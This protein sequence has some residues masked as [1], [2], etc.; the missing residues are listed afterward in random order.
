MP[1]LVAAMQAGCTPQQLHSLVDEVAGSMNPP[2]PAMYTHGPS[3][4]LEGTAPPEPLALPPGSQDQL[5]GDG[6]PQPGF[7]YAE[8]TKLTEAQPLLLASNEPAAPTVGAEAG[9]EKQGSIQSE[10]RGN[11]QLADAEPLDSE[12]MEQ[13]TA[14]MRLEEGSPAPL[15]HGQLAE[16]PVMAAAAHVEEPILQRSASPIAQSAPQNASPDEVPEGAWKT[17]GVAPT[18]SQPGSSSARQDDLQRSPPARNAGSASS[19]SQGGPERPLRLPQDQRDGPAADLAN[20]N[21]MAISEEAP[22]RE[23]TPGRL[24]FKIKFSGLSR[25]QPQQ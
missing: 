13:N 2:P 1:A 16:Q 9:V 25:Q 6:L 5:E 14:Q 8:D 12:T 15:A 19:D 11:D 22:L 4:E 3:E 7:D 21:D 20:G 18:L 24:K 10:G 17:V 23:G